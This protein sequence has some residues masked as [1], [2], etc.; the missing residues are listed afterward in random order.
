MLIDLT[1]LTEEELDSLR[2]EV[3]TEKTNRR[4]SK[5]RKL[6]EDFKNA[7]YALHNAGYEI[8]YSTSDFDREEFDELEDMPCDSWQNFSFD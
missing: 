4:D 5:R 2:L 1:S 6:I 7:F 3:E 8:W